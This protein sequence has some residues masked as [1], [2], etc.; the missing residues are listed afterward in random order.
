MGLFVKI[1]LQD[2][3]LAFSRQQG[4]GDHWDAVYNSPLQRVILQT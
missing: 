1:D 4:Q 3:A 2:A